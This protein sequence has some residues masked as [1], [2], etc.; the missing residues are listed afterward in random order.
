[1]VVLFDDNDNDNHDNNDN[2]DDD[3]H[4]ENGDEERSGISIN[5]TKNV[6]FF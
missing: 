3:N 4:D 2:H 5:V 6:F 1:M